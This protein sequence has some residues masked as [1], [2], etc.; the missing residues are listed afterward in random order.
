MLPFLLIL[1]IV[2]PIAELWLIIEIGGSIGVPLTLALLI[3]DSLVGAW[4]ARS[5][6]RAAWDRFN[7]ALAQSRVPGKE[8]FDGAMIIVGG[9]LLLTPG[10]ITDVFGLLFLIPPSRAAIRKF[11]TRRVTKRGR[12][13]F[14]IATFGSMRTGGAGPSGPR[15]TDYDFEGSARDVTEPT[16]ELDEETSPRRADG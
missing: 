11:V 8:V 3:V 7:Q 2:I 4:L 5:Q 1:F 13:P 12:V 16:P 9:A 6:S 14:K 15:Q 10:F